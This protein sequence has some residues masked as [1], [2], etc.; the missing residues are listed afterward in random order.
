LRNKA[1]DTDLVRRQLVK[2]LHSVHKIL[3]GSLLT[4]GNKH[5]K[6]MIKLILTRYRPWSQ[7]WSHSLCS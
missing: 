5:I 2:N 7:N 6:I 3:Y 1:S 4:P